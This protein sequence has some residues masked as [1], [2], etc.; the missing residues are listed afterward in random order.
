[1]QMPIVRASFRH[2][3]TTESSGTNL[4]PSPAAGV[5]VASAP[6]R[7]RGIVAFALCRRAHTVWRTI[8]AP[9]PKDL[10]RPVC[11]LLGAARRGTLSLLRAADHPAGVQTLDGRVSPSRSD[12]PQHL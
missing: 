3:M 12:L 5:V 2:G 11:R 10:R 6:A 1:M 7:I 4:S 9:R 8:A